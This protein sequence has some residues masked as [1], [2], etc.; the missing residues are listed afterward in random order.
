MDHLQDGYIMNTVT[1]GLGLLTNAIGEEQMVFM[2]V[3]P[4]VLDVGSVSLHFWWFGE[5]ARKH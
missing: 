5:G 4:M 1:M 3:P 2:H